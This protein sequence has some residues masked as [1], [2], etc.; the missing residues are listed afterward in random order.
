MSRHTETAPS[1]GHGGGGY[2]KSDLSVKAIVTFAIVLTAVIIM[3][4]ISMA[5]L[6]DFFDLWQTRRDVSPSPLASTRSG[7][8]EPRL[9]VNPPQDLKAFRAAEE[10]ILM[11]YG[12]VN[13]EAG[14]ARI[15]IE[16]AM[17]LVVERG[18]SAPAKTLPK[19]PMREV[20]R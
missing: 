16:R 3:A 17:E 4:L 12:W 13:K 20:P 10:R 9:Q 14:I 6:F 11:D 18:L 19:E 1:A 2:E 15:P 8:Q 5:W 7:P